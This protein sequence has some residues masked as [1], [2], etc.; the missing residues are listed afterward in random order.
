VLFLPSAFLLTSWFIPLT[1]T[2]WDWLDKTLFFW[3]QSSLEG[4]LILSIFWATANIKITD[5]YG[6]FFMLSFFL[7]LIYKSPKEDRS[8][9]IAQL[10]F[11]LIWFEIA[12]FACKQ[13]ATPILEQ[14]GLGR[15]SPSL[16]YPSNF[17]LSEMIPW[18]KVK[19]YSH[20]SIPADHASIVLQWA[21]FVWFFFGWHAGL[22]AIISSTL[23]ILP[24]LI[25]G[26]H[27][28]TDC[29]IG[30]LPYVLLILAIAV[31]TP[32]GAYIYELTTRVTKWKRNK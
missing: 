19:D 20:F 32:I 16:I 15:H 5:L 1:R 17:R 31:A 8:E 27:W 30:S 6:A 10:I 4:H 22:L 24:R 13:I 18:L 2:Y 9:R 7:L 25:S 29:L 12:I 11:T 3:L 21:L 26:A 23:F 28:L 14:H